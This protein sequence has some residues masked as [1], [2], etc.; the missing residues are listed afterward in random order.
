MRNGAEEIIGAINALKELLKL[1]GLS[2][3]F[4]IEFDDN[5]SGRALHSFIVNGLGIAGNPSAWPQNGPEYKFISRDQIDI[6]GA[7]IR[8][9]IQST[10]GG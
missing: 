10:P 9:P 3:Q 7:R 8:W 4:H 5:V 6:S 1:N 2:D